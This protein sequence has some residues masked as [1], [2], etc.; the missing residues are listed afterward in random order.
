MDKDKII[1][2]D[3]KVYLWV[4][5]QNTFITDTCSCNNTVLKNKVCQSNFYISFH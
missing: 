1:S 3:R 5:D 2:L 4:G